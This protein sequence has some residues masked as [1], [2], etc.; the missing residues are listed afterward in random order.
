MNRS[1]AIKGGFIL[2]LAA[3]AVYGGGAQVGGHHLGALH[4]LG[5]GALG[6]QLAVVE[7]HHAVGQR[8]HGAHHV[9]DEDDG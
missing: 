5:R 3:L 1:M 4:H 8:H 9:L 6:E 2:A 7:H